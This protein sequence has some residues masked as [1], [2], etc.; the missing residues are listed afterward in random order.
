MEI[1][2]QQW[3]ENTTAAAAD[4]GGDDAPICTFK[5][6]KI[7]FFKII[8]YNYLS[9]ITFAHQNVALIF[10]YSRQLRI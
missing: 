10:S 3:A 6:L 8:S 1:V 2:A 5:F 9:C 4:G 7:L